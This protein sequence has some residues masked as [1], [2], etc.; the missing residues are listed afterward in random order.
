MESHPFM[1]DIQTLRQRARTRIEAGA[2]TEGYAA[3]R[4]VAVKLLNEALAPELVC[5][6][7]YKR[8]FFMASGINARGR[9]N[10][11]SVETVSPRAAAGAPRS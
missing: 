4:E 1:T 10:V 5:V 2:V 9:R 6:L 11:P 3:D 7:R 8:H